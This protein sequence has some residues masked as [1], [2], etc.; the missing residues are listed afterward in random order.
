[1]DIQYCIWNLLIPGYS[2]SN[3]SSDG[4]QL[5][6]DATLYGRNFSP[7]SFQ[8]AAIVLYAGGINPNDNGAVPEDVLVEYPVPFMF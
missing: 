4:L 7:S 5:L 3:M 2:Q 1:M 8:T 6:S